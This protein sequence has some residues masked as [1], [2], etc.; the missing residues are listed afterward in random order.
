MFPLYTIDQLREKGWV[1]EIT[2]TA[3][4]IYQFLSTKVFADLRSFSYTNT[5][6]T[7]N[8]A[9][10]SASIFG[11][12][13]E[14]GY[15]V[16]E[17]IEQI[18]VYDDMYFAKDELLQWI[19]L[20]QLQQFENM[21]PDCVQMAYQSAL[22]LIISQIG[23]LYDIDAILAGDTNE[24]TKKTFRWILIVI[25]AY[26]LTAPS[27]QRSPSLEDNFLLA[28]NRLM[29]LKSGAST[30]QNAPIKQERN[31]WPAAVNNRHKMLG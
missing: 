14:F 1:I 6:Q 29:E 7:S 27:A 4:N 19:S 30:M 5:E 18:P 2:Q 3:N 17:L 24:N 26:N 12:Y 23:E 11:S 25:T 9:E 22:G 20:S 31:A 8:Q 21:Y 28:K 16:V 15:E 13:V 10:Y